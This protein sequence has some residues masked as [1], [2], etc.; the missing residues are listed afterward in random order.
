[1]T[2]KLILS[3][4]STS[5]IAAS[6]SFATIGYADQHP[7]ST[8]PSSP[9]EPYVNSVELRKPQEMEKCLGVTKDGKE[10]MLPK[11]ICEKLTN[12]IVTK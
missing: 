8:A 12:G 3:I 6:I 5:A 7:I 2:S 1:M 9:S 4:I 11:G 10:I